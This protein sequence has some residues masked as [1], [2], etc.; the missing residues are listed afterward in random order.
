[1]LDVAADAPGDEDLG[2]LML[3]LLV[4]WG[5]FVFMQFL[6]VWNS[7]LGSDAP[8]YV[9]ARGARLGDRRRHHLSSCISWCRSCC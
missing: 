8:W 4:L 2:K 3:A 7:D 6:I 9:T 1:M 5:Y